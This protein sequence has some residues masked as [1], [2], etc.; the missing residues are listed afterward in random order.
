MKGLSPRQREVFDF[1]DSYIKGNCIS[2]SIVEIAN[3]LGLSVTTIFTYAGALKK[4]GYLTWREFTPRSFRII[5]H[6][7]GEPA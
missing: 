5:K 3:G 6:T 1:I 7:A 2:P 4:K